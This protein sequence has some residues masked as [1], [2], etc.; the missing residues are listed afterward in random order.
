M[1]TVDEMNKGPA[2][3]PAPE[4][5]P[6]GTPLGSLGATGLPDHALESLKL[7]QLFFLFN[8]IISAACFYYLF[9]YLFRVSGGNLVCGGQK[10]LESILSL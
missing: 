3:C 7:S 2:T 6:P 1:K 8:F 5:L 9:P 10:T 4:T